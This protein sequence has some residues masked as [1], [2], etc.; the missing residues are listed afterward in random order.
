MTT[1]DWMLIVLMYGIGALMVG[2][3][4]EKWSPGFRPLARGLSRAAQL[5]ASIARRVRH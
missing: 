1:E 4:W 3:V 5:V 2:S